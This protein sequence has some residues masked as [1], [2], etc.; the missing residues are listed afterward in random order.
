MRQ[1]SECPICLGRDAALFCV[2]VDR[3]RPAPNEMWRVIRCRGCGFGWT[4]PLLSGSELSNYYPSTYLGEIEARIGEFL[5]GELQ[6][7]RS[8]RG[9]REKVQLVERY[10]ARGRILDVGCGDGKFLWALPP[11]RYERAGIERSSETVNLVRRRIQDLDLIAGDIHSRSLEPRRYDVIT[12]WHVF[13]HLQE[14]ALVLRRV[15]ELL[16]PGG[17]LFISLPCIDSVQARLFRRFWYGFDDVPRHL[18][19]F[20]EASLNLLLAKAGFR[21]VEHLL[22]SPLVNFHSLK[23]SL[24]N[25]NGE[26]FRSRAPYYLLKPLLPC[27]QVIER[28]TGRYGI[29]TVIASNGPGI[30]E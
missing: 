18:H 22:F 23:H 13:E 1:R 7:S 6:R 16:R 19:H 4:E 11:D 27:L 15:G 26:R 8:W 17:W 5:S 9:E 21:V 30:G 2:A 3:V 10:A 24:L 12:F 29:R 20:S 14:P 28:V 25:W